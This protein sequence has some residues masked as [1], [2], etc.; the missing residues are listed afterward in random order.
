MTDFNPQVV[1]NYVT[2]SDEI[3]RYVKQNDHLF[4]RRDINSR[5]AHRSRMDGPTSQFSSI[6]QDKMPQ[7]LQDMCLETI[8]HDRKWLS[9]LVIN[10][11]EPGDFLVKHQDSQGGYYKF[12]LVWLTDGPPHFCWYNEKDQPVLVQEKKGAMFQMDIGLA[13]EVT[14]IQPGEPTKYSLCLIWR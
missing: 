6:F 13:H 3:L 1:E 2:N 8:P 10:K 5:Y 9:Q 14:E 12:K 7:E 4:S 11:Y